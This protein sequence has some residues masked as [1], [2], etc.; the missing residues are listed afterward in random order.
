MT[1]SFS[2]TTGVITPNKPASFLIAQTS[3]ADIKKE[4]FSTKQR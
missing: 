3:R 2:E 1:S 4:K